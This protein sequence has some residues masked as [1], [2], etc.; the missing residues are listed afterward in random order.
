MAEKK[1]FSHKFELGRLSLYFIMAG[2]AI[3]LVNLQ[4]LMWGNMYFYILIALGGLYILLGLKMSKRHALVW[5]LSVVACTLTLLWGI[6]V[7]IPWIPYAGLYFSLTW[8]PLFIVFPA[9]AL[10]ILF[11]R[12][13]LLEFLSKPK[14]ATSPEQTGGVGRFLEQYYDKVNKPGTNKVQSLILTMFASFV[15]CLLL[16]NFFFGGALSASQDVKDQ[17]KMYKKI[18]I[19]KNTGSKS[20]GENT[21]DGDPDGKN[22][23][24]RVFGF[25][26]YAALMFVSLVSLFYALQLLIASV[27]INR[28]RRKNENL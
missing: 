3:S 18:T 19:Y 8:L 23:P 14:S 16:A 7:A 1:E 28:R 10:R 11:K 4:F 25:L 22:L 6:W 21:R 27:Y 17:N 5:W 2:A 9:I 26:A 24:G 20:T 15:V 12:P 13:L